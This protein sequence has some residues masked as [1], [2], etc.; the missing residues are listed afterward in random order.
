MTT[1]SENKIPGSLYLICIGRFSG[2]LRILGLKTDQLRK[3]K[4]QPKTKDLGAR[5]WGITTELVEIIP[6]SIVLISVVLG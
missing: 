3:I 1:E 5:L 4:I 2:V 6:K